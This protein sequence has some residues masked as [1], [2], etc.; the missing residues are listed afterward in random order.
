MHLFPLRLSVY[1]NID[2]LPVF[3]LLDLN[4]FAVSVAECDPIVTQ[5]EGSL[6]LKS[7]FVD[8]TQYLLCNLI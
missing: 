7:G 5:I 8:L 4:V 3:L 2:P 6:L 1:E